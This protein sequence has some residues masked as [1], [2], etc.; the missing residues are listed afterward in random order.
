MRPVINL[1]PRARAAYVLQVVGRLKPDVSIR[2]H[3]L[4]SRRSPIALR[5]NIRRP[6]KGV[7]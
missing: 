2:L 6:T 1:P 5:S 3:R 4:I 7:V